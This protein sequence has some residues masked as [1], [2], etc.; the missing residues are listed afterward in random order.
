MISSLSFKLSFDLRSR[1]IWIL[2]P[3]YLNNSQFMGNKIVKYHAF[4]KISGG[5]VFIRPLLATG[6]LSK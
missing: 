2:S 3:V 5:G 4:E 1:M 6:W